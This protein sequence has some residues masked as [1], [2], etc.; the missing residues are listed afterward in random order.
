MNSPATRR[1]AVLFLASWALA[2]A[3]CAALLCGL[4]AW[5]ARRAGPPGGMAAGEVYPSDPLEGRPGRAGQAVLSGT[6]RLPRGGPAAG[7]LVSADCGVLRATAY[8]PGGFYRID[9]LPEGPCRVAARTLG[10]AGTSA[11]TLPARGSVSIDVILSETN[12][13]PYPA[14]YYRAR[15]SFPNPR[16]ETDFRM[17]CGYCHQIGSRITRQSR[18]PETWAAL[19]QHM[20]GMGALLREETARAL[21]QV[22]AEGLSDRPLDGLPPPP[23]PRRGQD[24]TVVREWAMGGRDAYIHD[25][26]VGPDGALYGVDMNNDTVHSLDPSTGRERSWRLADRGHPPGGYLRA[27][28]RPIGTLEARLAPHSVEWA[29]GL[30]WITASLANEIVAFDPKDGSSRRWSLPAGGFYPHTH[31]VTAQEVWF[32]VALSNHLGR[33]DRS[34]GR[35]QL[36]ALPASHWEQSL[37]RKLMAPMLGLASLRP[38]SDSHLKLNIGRLTG[39]GSR[40]LALPYGLSLAPD[41]AVWYSK[42]YDDRVGRY[43]PAT[44]ILR[45]W[46]TPFHGPRRL[47]VDSAGRVWIPGFGSGVLA[48]FDPSSEAF[49]AYPLPSVP[50]AADQPYAVALEPGTGRVWVTSTLMDVLYRFDPASE[51]FEVFPLPTRA[52]F[53]RDLEFAPDGSVCGTYSNLPDSHMPDPTPKVFCLHAGG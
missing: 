9:G 4:W 25:I 51:S 52:A 28:R 10:R 5:L 40:P 1:P 44:G 22:L 48:R 38:G 13:D 32:T 19:I 6:A 45:E 29:D 17:Q 8:A 27:A 18:D 37:S 35:V 34:S 11:V 33:L 26:A 53:V 20:S 21:P 49:S 47:K 43:D 14:S 46:R 50:V 16:I 2:A 36:V 3:G 30:L 42:L 39:S 23:A 15:L 12:P 7:A 41:G 31:Q 24:R